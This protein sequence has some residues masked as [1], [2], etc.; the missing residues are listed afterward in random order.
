MLKVKSFVMGFGLTMAV[1]DSGLANTLEQAFPTVLVEGAA[2]PFRQFNKVEITGSS[3]IRKEQTQSLP[4][5]V[6]TRAEIVNSGKHDVAEFLQ[7]LPVMS[8][9]TT[10]L[11]IAMTNGGTYGAA[12]HGMQS[13]TL[14][15]INGRRLAPYGRQAIYQ[16][17]DFGTEL[18]LLPLSAIDRI[19]ILTDGASSIY[20][21]DALAG[22]VNIITRSER[23]GVE[24]TAEQRVPD[25]S[26]GLGRRVDLSAGGGKLQSDGYSWFV[27]ADLQH[28]QALMGSDRPYAAQGQRIVQ[29]DGQTYWVRDP[30]TTLAQTS[31]TLASSI[32]SPAK[33]WSANYQ[34]GSCPNGGVPVPGQPACNYSPMWQNSLYPQEDA[35]RLHAQGQWA[36]S[37]D[38]VLFAEYGYQQN[39]QIRASRPWGTYTAQIANRPDAPGYALAVAQGFDPA[40]GAW[41]LYSG[42]DLGLG[43]RQYAMQTHRLVTGLKGQWSDWD[44]RSA[45]YFS[46]NQARYGSERFT[47]Y[48][49]LGV[50]DQGFLTNP[51]LLAPLNSGTAA[52]QVL[53]AQLQGTQY[54][55]NTD[56]GK[57]RLLGV[58][59]HASRAVGERYGKDVLLA[60]G[61]DFH[62]EHNRYRTFM[63]QLT[64]PD[65]EG[66]RSVWAQYVELQAALLPDV[67]TIG[68]LRNDHYSDFGNTTHAKLSAK[69]TPTEQWLLRAAV[70]SGFRAPTISQLQNTVPSSG[71]WAFSPC[72][73]ELQ[74]IASR[75]GASCPA[76]AKYDIYSQGNPHLKPELSNQQSLGLRYSLSRNHTFWVDYWR[77][78]V[79]NRISE[80]AGE[81]I[82]AD[83]QAFYQYFEK[84]DQNQLQLHTS[85]VN[86]GE[87]RKSGVDF[88]WALRFPTDLGQ[89][90]ARIGGTWM[91][92]SA[93]TLT[94]NGSF[95][96]DL[97]TL[98]GYF[99]YVTPRLRMQASLALN[100]PNWTWLATV[101]YV[102]AYDD[103]GFT[104]TNA[105]TGLDAKVDH[106]RVPRWCTLDLAVRH[107]VSRQWQL[108]LGVEN[109]FNQ[110]SPLSFGTYNPL[111]FGTNPMYASLWGRT[112]NLAATYRF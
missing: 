108:M 101:N 19:E 41:L 38:H 46:S 1:L 49:N 83:P 5:Q 17:N 81:T 63:P 99:G 76:N 97:N 56:V 105:S 45:V 71:S 15:L 35:V 86:L 3:I 61:S 88:G 112:V 109:L 95:I 30:Q 67:E 33:L 31:T 75:L 29:Q 21:T 2:I 7:A 79:R 32:N 104:G 44:Y 40:Q 77:I 57:T 87:T 89:W 106:H 48:P 39:R 10:S 52:S 6:I 18:N 34:N 78:R 93:Y 20:G 111:L 66:R 98:S 65:F 53:L 110:K 64:Q 58:E 94:D 28:Q 36:L 26:K 85:L 42:S 22:V 80:L 68:A 91:M 92:R 70:G 100:Q 47:D 50:D 107:E 69:W 96:S 23:P 102:G 62:Q 55:N 59:V 37:A 72:T 51:A 24:I 82:L 74:S 16:S 9:F 27:A 103:G 54:W 14:V 60:L 84:N 73:A 4:V 8:N 11:D 90:H 25:R 12:V 43:A 13:Y